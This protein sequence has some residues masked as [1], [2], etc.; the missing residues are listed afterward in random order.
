MESIWTKKCK[1]KY[2]N[3]KTMPTHCEIVVIG[4]GM[5]GL[6]I[7]YEL[8]KAEKE[9]IILEKNK[10][11]SGQTGNTTAKITSQHNLIY[12]MLIQKE[13]IEK[14]KQYA[15]A[16]QEAIEAY[17]KIITEE[18]I[19]CD[20]ERLDSFVYSSFPDS[21]IKKEFDAAIQLG[22]PAVYNAHPNT[23]F[24]IAESVGFL[25]QAQFHPLK[26]INGIIKNMTI[27]ED[28]FVSE[29]N[30]HIIYTNK[31]E[32]HADKIIIATHYPIINIPGYYFLKM[33]QERSYVVV[34]KEKYNLK[35]MY[36]SCDENPLSF[37][38]M[39]KYILVGGGKHRT[40]ENSKGGKYDE[41]LIRANLL[42]KDSKC[43]TRYS[44]QD[45]IT[46]D[47]IPYIGIYSSSTP[48]IY[49]ATGF[50]K[51][52]MTSS[53]VSAK[54]IKNDILGIANKNTTVFDTQ[55]IRIDSGYQKLMQNGLQA[56][57]GLTKRIIHIP[58]TELRELA[59]G[60][61]GVVTYNN[62][63][64]GVYKNNDGETFIVSI[65]CPHLGCQL[66]WNPD[67]LSWDCPCHGSRF[68]YK[69]NLLDVPALSGIH[70]EEK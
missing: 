8:Q 31:G 65:K 52:G 40:G 23:P 41:L 42:F 10:I 35:G 32:I 64:I 55:R 33:H 36:I 11:A 28:T 25:N 39:N 9:V 51:W 59:N 43:I 2:E 53:M 4:A 21:R 1:I 30:E 56:V 18:D 57:K 17:E 44:A 27:F 63:K 24:E 66:E 16:N 14:A 29:I 69:G 22:L 68:D 20:F 7:A 60:H 19:D 62:E 37:R 26:F 34:L 49:V 46:N 5:A 50:N 54:I 3:D 12:D 13:G 47:A 58:D 6:L 61:G 67:E 15:T 70:N 45:C 38:N 48:H